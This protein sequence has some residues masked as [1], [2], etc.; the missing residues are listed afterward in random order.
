MEVT[1]RKEQPSNLKNPK[2]RKHIKGGT[3][4]SNITQLNRQGQYYRIK[5]IT[6]KLATYC[7]NKSLKAIHEIISMA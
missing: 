7:V 3:G 2:R 4:R 6:T 5:I 1:V